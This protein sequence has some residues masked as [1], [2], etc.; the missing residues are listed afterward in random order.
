MSEFHS[1]KKLLHGGPGPQIWWVGIL[2]FL[3]KIKRFQNEAT[4]FAEALG[5]GGDGQ[6]RRGAGTVSGIGSRHLNIHGGETG[7]CT[8]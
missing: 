7:R 1:K 4:V 5:H 3:S 2:F 6:D 8:H